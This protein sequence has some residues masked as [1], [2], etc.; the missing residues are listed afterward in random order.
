MYICLYNGTRSGCSSS[1]YDRI[2]DLNPPLRFR[3]SSHTRSH[4][5]LVLLMIA[6]MSVIPGNTGEMKVTV[7][8][9]SPYSVLIASSLLSM[10]TALSISFLNDSSSVLMENDTVTLSNSFRISRSLRVQQQMGAGQ[11]IWVKPFETIALLLCR[12][13]TSVPS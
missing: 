7:R 4:W 10:L 13:E 3:F 5:S 6:S 11:I 2:S 8:M 9:P 1:M 12:K